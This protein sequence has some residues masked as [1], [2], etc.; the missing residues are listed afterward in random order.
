MRENLP[1][2]TAYIGRKFDRFPDHTIKNLVGS[3]A[4]GRLFRAFSEATGNNLAFKI[5]PAA[6]LP[7]GGRDRDAYLLEAKNANQLEHASVIRCLDVFPDI[8]PDGAGQNVVFVF[9][10]VNGVDLKKYIEQAPRTER[11]GE[12]E[13]SNIT[14]PFVEDFLRTM[15]EVLYELKQRKSR[16]GDLHAGNVLVARSEYDVYGRTTFRATD[17]GVQQVSERTQGTSD[18]LGVAHMLRQLLKC[19]EYRDC[20]GRDRFVYDMLRTDFLQRHLIETDVSA[21]PLAC[22]PGSMLTKLNSLDDRYREESKR[23]STEAKL[24]T[25]FDYP[26][27]EQMGNSHLLLKSLYSDRLSRIVRHPRA[28]QHRTDR[29]A[30]LRKDH[31]IPRT[32][33]GLLDFR[34][35]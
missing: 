32:E 28:F 13:S 33:P 6:N 11:R 16:H 21:D 29:P 20:G 17:F 24:V 7:K 12:R 15:L 35:R 2:K 4:N 19:I 34:G 3:G 5:V 30:W 23:N 22:Q 9:D 8:D 25:P 10:Y 1:S 26:N 14:V 27:C 18:Y 31:R